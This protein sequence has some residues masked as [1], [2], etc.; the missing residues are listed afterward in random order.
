M[1]ANGTTRDEKEDRGSYKYCAEEM[2][3]HRLSS[4]DVYDTGLALDRFSRATLIEQVVGFMERYKQ[5]I[6]GLG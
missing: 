5:S 6:C 3:F 1:H 2:G 4:L